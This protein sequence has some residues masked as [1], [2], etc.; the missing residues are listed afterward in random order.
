MKRAGK[1][2][3][4]AMVVPARELANEGWSSCERTVRPDAHANREAT[5]VEELELVLLDADAVGKDQEVALKP[6]DGNRIELMTSSC[7][8]VLLSRGIGLRFGAELVISDVPY[9]CCFP[10]S[11]S[12]LAR[13]PGSA[14]F[15]SCTLLPHIYRS[16]ARS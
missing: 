6:C 1:V 9:S 12:A 16:A 3:H 15:G 10:S 4:S 11:T 13:Q 2:D 5:Y 14:R 8:F 7:H